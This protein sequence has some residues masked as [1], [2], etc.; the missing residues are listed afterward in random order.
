MLSS[1]NYI[2]GM[3]PVHPSIPHLMMC[4]GKIVVG[5]YAREQRLSGQIFPGMENWNY[6]AF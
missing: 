4:V 1:K 3:W 5:I 6:S 2:A